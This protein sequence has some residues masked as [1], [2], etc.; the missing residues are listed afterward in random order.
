[1]SEKK[2]NRNWRLTILV[3]GI[4]ML[5]AVIYYSVFSV[6][7]YVSTSQVVVR[8]AGTNTAS[9]Q[10][11]GLSLLMGGI[12]PTSREETLYLRQFIDST[13]MLGVLQKELHWSQHYADQWRDPLYWVNAQATTEDLIDYYRRV[14][15]VHYDEI[16]GL[17]TVDVEALSPEFAKK[18]QDVILAES[19]RFVNELTHKM[20]REQLRFAEEELAIA[21]KGYEDQREALIAFQSKN[22]LLDAQASAE[23]RAAIIADLESKLTGERAALTGLRSQLSAD[24]PQVRQQHNRIAALEKQLVDERGKLVSPLEGGHLNVI[25]ARYRNLMVDAGIAEEAYKLSVT[26]LENARIETSKKIRSLVTVVQPNMPQEALYPRRIYNLLT[27]LIALCLIYGITR[28]IIAS[29][30]DHRD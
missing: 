22:N 5:L 10:V 24:S 9:Q 14:V 3:I 19:E 8:Q 12:N 25:A 13:D 1:M 21:R 6:K 29:I 7:R 28:F 16:T 20:A 4:P 2:E 18:V 17:L 27:L 11:P 30:E 26:A 23:S 15:T